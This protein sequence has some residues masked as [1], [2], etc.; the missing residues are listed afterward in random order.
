[1]K[2]SYWQN[3]PAAYCGLRLCESAVG[4]NCTAAASCIQIQW[5][6]KRASATALALLFAPRSAKSRND[7]ICFQGNRLIYIYGRYDEANPNLKEQGDIIL[8]A[9]EFLHIPGLGFD[10]LVG[11]SPIAL[12]KNAIG[13]SIACEEYGASFFEN[14]ASP[15]GVLEHPRVIKNPE[16]VRDIWQKAYGVRNAHKVAVLEEGVRPDRTLSKA[17]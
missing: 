9:D 1:M 5:E 14:G 8:Y 11:Y 13:I 15:S 10:G 6:R 3:S 12:A 2:K 4:S 16:R 17:A 7:I